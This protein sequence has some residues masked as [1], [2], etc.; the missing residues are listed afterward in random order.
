MDI[1]RDRNLRFITWSHGSAK[2]NIDLNHE[3]EDW[4]YAVVASSNHDLEASVVVSPS[5]AS[6]RKSSVPQR[7]RSD[8]H[9]EV[10]AK[11]VEGAA[12]DANGSNTGRVAGGDSGD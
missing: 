6:P 2:Q 5:G 12:A 8:H 7:K 10:V 4:Y 1:R 9:Q 11:L 3:T